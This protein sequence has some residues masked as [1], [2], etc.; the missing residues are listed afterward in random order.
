MKWARMYIC[1]CRQS[2]NKNCSNSFY[3]HLQSF[4]SSAILAVL[5]AWLSFEM[6]WQIYLILIISSVCLQLVSG[7]YV[8]D[9]LLIAL[10]L[11]DIRQNQNG[12]LR[13]ILALTLLKPTKLL[14]AI[15]VTVYVSLAG[16]IGSMVV[17]LVR[18]E[19]RWNA[20]RL[21]ISGVLLQVASLIVAYSIYKLYKITNESVIAITNST[22]EKPSKVALHAQ[23]QDC[24][25]DNSSRRARLFPSPSIQGLTPQDEYAV[26]GMQSP[27]RKSSHHKRDL[28]L[29]F[30]NDIISERHSS[31]KNVLAKT[32]RHLKR[33]L[34]ITIIGSIIISTIVMVFGV[35]GIQLEGSYSDFI[36]DKY[37]R[38]RYRLLDDLVLYASLFAQQFIIVF[39]LIP[40]FWAK[41]FPCCCCCCSRFQQVHVDASTA[42]SR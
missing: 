34:Y 19:V 4:R 37:Y 39:S 32:S 29:R 31:R 18:N 36:A 33:L 25:D 9:S 6:P 28:S 5:F 42:I 2:E 38:G 20:L 21:F 27:Y 41:W 30:K 40:G 15:K 12:A 16:I 24:K 10:H 17:I 8:V 22:M 3:V 23:K 35:Q 11:I 1:V 7:Y 14:T 26:S 13:K